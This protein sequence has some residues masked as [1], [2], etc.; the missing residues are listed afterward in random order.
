[1]CLDFNRGCCCCC[2]CC[3]DG[4]RHGHGP[5]GRRSPRMDHSPGAPPIYVTPVMVQ[6]G[7]AR[8]ASPGGYY[9]P[10]PGY[11]SGQRV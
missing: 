8:M 1:M 3:D 5:G 2:V 4:D 9:P 7:Y 10:P 6:P 11:P